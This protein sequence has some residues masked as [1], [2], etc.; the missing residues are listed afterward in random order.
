MTPGEATKAAR[1]LVTGVGGGI[2]QSIIKSLGDSDYDVV[3]VDADPLAAGLHAVTVGRLVPGAGDPS[4]A[5]Q[6]L[7]VCRE[8]SCALVFPGLDGELPV[9]SRQRS[10]FLAEGVDVV[11]SRPE[12]VRICDDKLETSTFLS[13]NGFATPATVRFTD[14]V[15]STWFP[16]VLKPRRGG[17]RSQGVHVVES[18]ADLDRLGPAIDP[19][20]YVIQERILGDEFTC[21]T[22][23][24][25]GSCRG[26][27]VMWRTL[28][29]G[30]TYKAF[31][32]RNDV[33]EDSIAQVADAL[34]PYGA[35][36]FQCRL[37]N[38]EPVI[39]EINA[40]CSG[41]TAA[42]ALAGFN[43]PRMIADYLLRGIAPTH[44]I[45]PIGVLRYWN[46]LVV[47]NEQLSSLASG[48]RVSSSGRRL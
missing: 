26:V 27:I 16:F 24:L 32:V 22:V 19:S 14:D 20:N 38:G 11:V 45:R 18:Q 47:D 48:G 43:E 28:R 37:K 42:R 3:G 12:V 10:A 46:E 7:A 17:S 1:V 2:G 40:R 15:D 44:E 29:A 25:D 23:N 5:E 13:D 31:V 4:Y 21:G 41:T 36:N 8:E 30:D 9:L 35:C 33:I 6:L 39:F 34:R